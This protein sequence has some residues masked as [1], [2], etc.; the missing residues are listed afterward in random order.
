MSELV[1][2][3]TGPDADL[4]AECG[5]HGEFLEVVTDAHRAGGRE[6]A[7]VAAEAFVAALRERA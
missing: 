5:A 1:C 6:A 2:R 3:L 7:Q 4:L